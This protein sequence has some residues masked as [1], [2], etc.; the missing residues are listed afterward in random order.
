MAS[1]ALSL[2]PLTNRKIKKNGPTYK[3][4]ERECGPPPRRSSPRRSSPRRLSSPQ[5][6]LIR[7]YNYIVEIM[8]VMR[9]NNGTKILGTRYQCLKKG[10]GKGLNEPILKYNNDYE[11]IEN[12]RIYCGNGALPNIK[13]DLVH[14]MNV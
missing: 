9:I 8:H 13:I 12:V 4:L 3:E 1:T 7:E 10:I 5:D 2:Y 14:E 6:V 11:P